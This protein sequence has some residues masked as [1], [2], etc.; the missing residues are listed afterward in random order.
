[1]LALGKPRK[2]T[3]LIRGD[4]LRPGVEVKPATPGVLPPLVDEKPT[5]MDLAKWLVSPENPLTSRVL[6]N[7][8][9]QK[10]FGRGLVTTLEG[11]GTQGELP[12]H[13]K[14][15]DWL[16]SEVQRRK[17]SLKAMHKLI[18]T[19]AT[20][21]QSAKS[22]PELAQ[23]DPMNVLLGRQTRQRLEAEIIRDEA[24]AASG[25]LTRTVRG[26]S[27]RPPQPPGPPPPPHP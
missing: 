7:W 15:L 12:S 24:L 18:V 27:R 1:T 4:F 16:A 20:Y 21:R 19:S 25:L 10:Y 5:R 14:L 8:M 9:W 11:F 22:R 3:V 13:P 2:T 23:G 6:V 17:W 26:P